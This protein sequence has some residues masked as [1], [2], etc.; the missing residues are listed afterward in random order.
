[1]LGAA[2]L[3][4]VGSG[5]QKDFAGIKAWLEPTLDTFPN[6]ANAEVYQRQFS[7][8]AQLYGRLKDCFIT[9]GTAR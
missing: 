4:A 6:P 5:N 1:M 8:F 7:I 2:Y 9:L 3:A